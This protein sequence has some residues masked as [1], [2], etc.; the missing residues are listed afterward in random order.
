MTY[1][2]QSILALFYIFNK[3]KEESWMQTLKAPLDG[4]VIKRLAFPVG[5]CQEF[6]KSQNEDWL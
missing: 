2:Y 5:Q 6:C 1:Q 3:T 4:Q